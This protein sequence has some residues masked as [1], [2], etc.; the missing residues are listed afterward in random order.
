MTSGHRLKGVVRIEGTL[1]V[2]TGL[3]IGGSADIMEISGLDNPIIRNPRNAEPF[4]PGSSLRGRMRSLAEW[5][6][7]EL[8]DRGHVIR[9]K[10]G[11]RK[12]RVF[13]I[14][15]T[16]PKKARDDKEAAEYARGPT[17]LIVRDALLSKASRDELKRGS[18]I[19]EVKSENSIN[20]LTSVANPR[21]MERVLPG[22]SFVVEMTY[23]IFDLG[24]GGAEDEK[25]LNEVLLVA[26]RLLELD[27]LGG[28]G[29]RGNGKVVW[30]DLKR[31]GTPFSLDS[32]SIRGLAGVP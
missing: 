8:P 4:V 31:D 18:P 11:S 21:P 2:V 22:V 5:Y 19:T 10:I 27:A 24:D 15:A 30:R 1:E 20:R 7:A 25:N 14:P 32:V 23:R 9:P 28:G 3:R 16:D 29:S 6:F 17:R 26:M 13:G 12:A